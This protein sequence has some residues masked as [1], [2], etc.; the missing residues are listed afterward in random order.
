MYLMRFFFEKNAKSD[1]CEKRFR[2]DLAHDCPWYL[3]QKLEKNPGWP[4]ILKTEKNNYRLYFPNPSTNIFRVLILGCSHLSTTII[5]S[6]KSTN[7]A[8]QFFRNIYVS[9]TIFHRNYVF[10]QRFSQKKIAVNFVTI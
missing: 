9:N 10:L 1:E 3:L 7:L 4:F 5:P 8:R 2:Q 6:I